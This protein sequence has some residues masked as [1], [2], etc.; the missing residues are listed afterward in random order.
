MF[1][2][3]FVIRRH[4]ETMNKY[5]DRNMEIRRKKRLQS[6]HKRENTAEMFAQVNSSL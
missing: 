4:N 1:S 6:G 3:D 5:L 2:Y